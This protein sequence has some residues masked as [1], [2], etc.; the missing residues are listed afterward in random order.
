MP[1]EIHAVTERFREAK[2]KG[3]KGGTLC[4]GEPPLRAAES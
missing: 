1:G 2:K 3:R 4:G